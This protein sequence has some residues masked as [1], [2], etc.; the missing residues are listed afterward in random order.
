MQVKTHKTMKSQG[1]CVIVVNANL[2]TD[3]MMYTNKIRAA[4]TSGYVFTTT[5]GKQITDL[6]T[7]LKTTW[8]RLTGIDKTVSN[9]QV[10]HEVVK[11]V[12]MSIDK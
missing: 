6:S 2:W 3:L 12:R 4:S 8:K 7:S 9:T 5:T 10:R 11:N 1:P